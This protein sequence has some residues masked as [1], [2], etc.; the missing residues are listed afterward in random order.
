MKVDIIRNT[1][2]QPKCSD[3]DFLLPEKMIVIMQRLM[4]TSPIS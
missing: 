2:P 1:S 3:Q 4:E